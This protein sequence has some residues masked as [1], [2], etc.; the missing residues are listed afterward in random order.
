MGIRT[1]HRFGTVD[2][3]NGEIPGFMHTHLI[4]ED[5]IPPGPGVNPTLAIMM[6]A[7]KYGDAIVDQM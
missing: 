1:G 3:E 7:Q 4:G 5:A 2:K 6:L